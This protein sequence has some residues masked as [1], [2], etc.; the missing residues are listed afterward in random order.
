MAA[1]T[2]LSGHADTT[3]L[4]WDVTGGPVD[5]HIGQLPAERLSTLWN[6]LASK[7]AGK[8]FDAIG[9]LTMSPE[10]AISLLKSKLR[11][12]PAPAQPRQMT[13]LIADLD[14]EEFAVREKAR[15]QLRQLGE[16]AEPGLREALK[17]KLPLEARKRIEEL[18]EGVR[19]AAVAPENLRN[20]RAVETL[21][22]IGTPEAREVLKSLAN[23]APAARLTREAKAA[24]ERLVQRAP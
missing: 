14:S 19:E 5:R 4:I 7:D 2:P 11:P 9:M 17:D 20:L 12:A 23:G 16:R 8:A 13:R 22:H 3:A 21:E 1:S 10:Q 6:D 24:L 18:L 15:E